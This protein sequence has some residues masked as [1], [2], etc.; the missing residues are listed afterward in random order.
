MITSSTLDLDYR[1]IHV[2]V[3]LEGEPET[4][5]APVLVEP[6]FEDPG[7]YL[8]IKDCKFTGRKDLR[9]PRPPSDFLGSC[10]DG[11]T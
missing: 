3:A 5:T 7:I 8:V 10:S 4:T 11:L 9:S 2:G 6:A 1:L